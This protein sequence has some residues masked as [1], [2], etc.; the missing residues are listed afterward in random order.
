MVFLGLLVA[1]ALLYAGI[2]VAML[3]FQRSLIYFPQTSA[4][5]A[6]ITP[7]TLQT[8]GGSAIVCT[9]P[10]PGPDAVLYFGGNAEDVSL[11]MQGMAAAFPDHAIYLFNYPG[12]GGS[13]GRPS[14]RAIIAYALALFDRVHADHPNVIVIGRSLG[15]G[16]A[17]RL[18][19]ERPVFRLVLVTPFDSLA[20]VAAAHY[21]YFPVRWI[22]RD[23]FDSWRYAPQVAART[24]ILVAADDEVI[25]RASTERLL[26]RFKPGIVSY[27]VIPGVGHNTISESPEY[28]SL[29]KTP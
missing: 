7:M 14:E 1:L 17:V 25:P 16:A 5:Q 12:Y 15:S 28:W 19:S 9:R 18:A 20:N 27:N 24:R 11:N 23:K 22:I 3:A 26:A 10:R 2:C 4:V 6:G 21:R 13:P 8:P 29:L